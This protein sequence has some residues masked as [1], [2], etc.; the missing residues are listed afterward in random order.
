MTEAFD[1]IVLIADWINYDSESLE[2]Y[3]RDM[4]KPH[5]E[6]VTKLIEALR[7]FH[8][9][10]IHYDSPAGFIENIGKHKNDL[11]FPF[12]SG[13][14]SR[15]R[16][17][18]IPAICEG[19]NIR[20][21][22]G[23]TYTKIVCNDK[24][25]SKV[26]CGQAGLSTPKG[27]NINTEEDFLLLDDLTYPCVVKPMFEGTSLGI[28]DRNLVHSKA[29]AIPV[30]QDLIKEFDQPILAEEFVS[31]KE[32]SVCLIG[33]KDC[34]IDWTAAERYVVGDDG[35]FFDRLYGYHEKKTY[36]IPLALR[37][38][39]TEIPEEILKSCRKLFQLLDK[40]EFMR[41]DGR[42]NESGF[43]VFELTPETH[44]GDDAEFCGSFIAEGTYTYPEIIRSLVENCLARYRFVDGY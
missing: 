4:D 10:V 23:D 41:I 33:W 11:V 32:V 31:G 44:L 13:E 40:V 42:L 19:A 5:Q 16:Y 9:N 14:K 39:K 36:N 12:W 28:T 1:N 38:V 17:A 35:Y 30:I 22:G 2:V 29:E 20:Y 27:V 7:S 43:H 18:L 6:Y 3:D 34:I 25:L 37:T 24:T 8:P 26:L 21:I 15:N